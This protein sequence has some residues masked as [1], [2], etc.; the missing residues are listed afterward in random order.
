MRDINTY[1]GHCCPPFGRALTQRD[2]VTVPGAAA[3]WIDTLSLF[4]S[5]KVSMS[6]VLAPATRLADEGFPV[7]ELVAGSWQRQEKLLKTA[8]PNGHELL[9]DGDHAPRASEIFTNKTLARTFGEIAAKGKEGFYKGRIAEEIVKLVK[10]KGGVLELSDLEAHTSTPVDPISYHYHSSNRQGGGVTL[11]ETPPNGQGLAALMALGIL[12][13][14]E[15]SAKVPD[16]STVEHNG[17]V[18]LHA[19]IECLRFAFADVRSYVADPAKEKVPVEE[20]LSDAYL[21]ERAKLFDPK[22]A[23]ADV[24]K[25]SPLREAR[26][27]TVYLATADEHGNAC[28]F[29]MS[30]F[31]GLCV[32]PR[33]LLALETELSTQ[34]DRRGTGRVRLQ[35]AEPRRRVLVAGRAPELPRPIETTLPHH[36]SRDGHPRGRPHDGLWRHGRL[37]A[38]TGPR[39][40]LAQY[41]PSRPPRPARSR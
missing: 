28:S 13:K 23:V 31:D 4:G 15:A 9:V 8:S 2:S 34:R 39:P 24:Q 26:S 5:G 16:L 32:S 41:A 37:H 29:I 12:E 10:T 18:W 3:G 7:S 20:L 40:G 11:H 22:K 36:H 38:A 33:P 25:G 17:T 6:D 35:P 21:E 19:L 27:D 14:L 1:A 30:N